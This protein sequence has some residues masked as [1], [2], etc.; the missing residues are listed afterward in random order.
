MVGPTGKSRAHWPARAVGY[1]IFALSCAIPSATAASALPVQVSQNRAPWCCTA[2]TTFRI[3][4]NEVSDRGETERGSTEASTTSG[5]ESGASRGESA[6]GSEQSSSGSASGG[7]EHGGSGDGASSGGA[8]DSPAGHDTPETETGSSSGSTSSSGDGTPSGGETSSS[9]SGDGESEG[10]SAGTGQQGTSSRQGGSAT[11]GSAE[12]PVSASSTAAIE[13]TRDAVGAEYATHDIVV[14][15]TAAQV[16]VIRSNGFSIIE[17]SLLPGV[18]GSLL[19]LRVPDSQNAQSLLANLRAAVPSSTSDLDGVF[20]LAKS[21]QGNFARRS[22]REART[23]P[24]RGVV[25]LVDATVDRAYP[26]VR[27]AI[28][29]DRTFVTAPVGDSAHGTATAEVVVTHGANILAANVFA[30]DASGNAAATTAAIIRAIDWLVTQNVTVINLSFSGSQNTALLEA[31]RRAQLLGCIIVAAAGND[32][33][34]APAA[35]PAAYPGVIAVTAVDRLNK[36]YRYANRGGYVRFAALGVDV[37]TP[38]PPD[39]R[40]LESG[41]SFSAPVVAAAIARA[42]HLRAP[43]ASA[44]LIKWFEVHAIDLGDPGRDSVYGFGLLTPMR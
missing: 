16:A 22:Q 36:V 31:V 15:A 37:N 28:I 30:L 27:A 26:T 9:R 42:V 20:R 12:P 39:A 21:D 18:G 6:S 10:T 13:I 2:S 7:T 1:V 43:D 5:T 34:A 25:G 35:Y 33:P 32:G 11:A 17:E 41:T 38:V 3:A 14:L 24:A 19:T 8:Q 44:S 40:R 4:W 23:K 29:A